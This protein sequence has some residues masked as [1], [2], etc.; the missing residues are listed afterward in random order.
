V[1]G[2]EG[3]RGKREKERERGKYI[4]RQLKFKRMATKTCQE[5]DIHKNC[6]KFPSM[7]IQRS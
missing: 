6:M 5:M 3:E 2:R 7:L 4:Q 1:E